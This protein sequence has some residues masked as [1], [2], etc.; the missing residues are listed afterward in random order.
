MQGLKLYLVKNKHIKFNSQLGHVKRKVSCIDRAITI[1][2]QF[3][4]NTLLETLKI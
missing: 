1:Q 2:K 4:R 3:K